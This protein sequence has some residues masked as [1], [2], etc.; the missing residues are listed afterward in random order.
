MDILELAIQ[1]IR[2]FNTALRFTIKDGYNVFYGPNECGKT[3]L[4]ETILA[5]LDKK[6]ADEKTRTLIPFDAVG[7]PSR[8]G[9]VFK[10]GA[11]TLR[12]VKEFSNLLTT[13]SRAISDGKY[14]PLS[15]DTD[16]IHDYLTGTLG[17]PSGDILKDLLLSSS[18]E[19]EKAKSA[20]QPLSATLEESSFTES[21]ELVQ[22]A[23]NDYEL[24]EKVY[25]SSG[26]YDEEEAIKKRIEQL[27]EELILVEE[28]QKI[29]FQI[30]GLESQV[31]EI[32]TK[33]KEVN[34]IDEKIANIDKELDKLKAVENMPEGIEAK[35]KSLKE[36][37]EAKNR[38]LLALQKELQYAKHELQKYTGTPF[39]KGKTFIAGISTAIPFLIA[40][41]VLVVV[42]ESPLVATVTK[43]FPII[44]L[45]GWGLL[46][47]TAWNEISRRDKEKKAQKRLKE[48]QERIKTVEKKYE[49]E[50]LLLKNLL[51]QARLSD[52]EEL[53]DALENIKMLKAEKKQLEEEKKAL[54]AKYNLEG[55]LNKKKELEN[56]IKENNKRLLE[57]GGFSNDPLEIKREIERLK[58]TLSPQRGK[59][60]TESDIKRPST[61][62]TVETPPALLYATSES[63][64]LHII[65]LSAESMKKDTSEILGITEELLNSNLSNLS[66]GMYKA[67]RLRENNNIFVITKDGR[68]LEW[69]ELSPS[70]KE[71]IYF[72]LKL[73]ML[74]KII[75]FNPLPI[76]LDEPFLFSDE[77]RTIEFAKL[78]KKLSEKTKII[79]FTSKT[80]FAKAGNQV[81]NLK[82]V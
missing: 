25:Y 43:F 4:F 3:T 35:V 9:L 57:A 54:K 18:L 72:G 70:S 61:R 59:R 37:E 79:H 27:E 26:D 68:E 5:I 77:M 16:W 39:Y 58:A 53:L 65:K 19:Y 42:T 60:K 15:R 2:R 52:P 73:T 67:L 31:F 13:L 69:K 12:I 76:I 55:L 44:W 6:F 62:K 63:P 17:L 34:V 32:E 45:A 33:L 20:A 50:A 23:N 21:N 38:E 48:A 74:E 40:Q 75:E 80:I 78:L 66:G 22:D 49:V 24:S 8:A 1:G 29:Q 51:Q 81:Y 47:Y 41:F 82:G 71:T 28:I 56:T 10:V 30:D 64:L 7:S 36:Q 14:E 46:L 11:D